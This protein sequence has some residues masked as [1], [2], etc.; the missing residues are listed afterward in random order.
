VT[1]QQPRTDAPEAAAACHNCGATLIGRFCASCGQEAL[2]L[3]PT[4]RDL[5]RDAAHELLNVDARIVQSVRRLFCSPG[6]LTREYIEGRR[7]SWLPPLRLY[8]LFSVAYFALA[9][10]GDLDVRVTGQTDAETVAAVQNLG[11]A[12][13]Q[14]M[15]A[16]LSH[17]QAVWRPRVMFVLVPL[18]AWF[19]HLVRRK[20]GRAYPQHLL[21]A[22]HA[23]AA[24]FGARALSAATRLAVPAPAASALDAVCVV[25]GIVYVV[26][27][28]EV[29]YGGTRRRALRDAAI[30]L[31]LY[32]VAVIAATLGIVLPVLFWR[33]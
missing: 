25:Y 26:I 23:H 19:V 21:F 8:L 18:F 2:P 10:F 33:R 31:G 6:F 20:S 28:L 15:R 5:A 24:Y 3:N 16:A 22:L 14:E 32:W 11:F 29:A 12:N 27:G 17:A 13:E 30:V 9:T 4:V 7:V 1:T